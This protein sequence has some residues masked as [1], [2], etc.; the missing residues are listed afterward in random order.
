MKLTSVIGRFLRN[1]E[2]P[3][4][5]ISEETAAILDR[6]IDQVQDMSV[7]VIAQARREISHSERIIAVAEQAVRLTKKVE[8]SQ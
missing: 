5:K 6:Q 4:K 7:K 3:Q 2:S 1:E 8:R